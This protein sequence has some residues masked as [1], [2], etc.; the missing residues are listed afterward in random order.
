MA[1]AIH[2]GRRLLWRTT[3]WPLRHWIW[4]TCQSCMRQERSGHRHPKWCWDRTPVSNLTLG[5]SWSLIR[6]SSQLDGRANCCANGRLLMAMLQQKV[7]QSARTSVAGPSA[8]TSGAG[9]SAKTYATKR[10]IVG[11][12]RSSWMP[13][14][15]KRQKKARMLHF[16][17]LPKATI[18]PCISEQWQPLPAQCFW[19][20][21]PMPPIITDRYDAHRTE[22]TW[23]EIQQ[24]GLAAEF[25]GG[26]YMY[27][28]PLAA[29]ENMKYPNA[30]F[31]LKLEIDIPFQVWDWVRF[32]AFLGMLDWLKIDLDE[33]IDKHIVNIHT[34]PNIR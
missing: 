2:D 8:R 16:M 20:C 34:N 28:H 26:K 12:E 6:H 27:I 29:I 11:S 25:L 23:K 31:Q 18:V 10:T 13:T 9:P 1:H 5:T 21:V 7:Q 33:A 32:A 3:S 24:S 17:H 4:T 19:P 22:R 15:P 30:K 14:K